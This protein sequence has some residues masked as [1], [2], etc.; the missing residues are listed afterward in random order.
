MC[1]F[2][3]G[4][5]AEFEVTEESASTNHP[6]GTQFHSITAEIIFKEVEK[7]YNSV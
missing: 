3:Q 6:R 7:T 5:N 2:I 4:I 1:Y